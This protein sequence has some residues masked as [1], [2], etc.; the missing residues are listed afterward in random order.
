MKKIETL[1]IRET[2]FKQLRGMI[3]KNELRPGD[4]LSEAELAERL[5]VSRTPIREALHKLELEDLIEIQPRRYCQVKGI[6]KESIN[7]INL[8]RAQLEPLVA[9]DAVDHLTDDELNYIKEVLDRSVNYFEQ[10]DVYSLIEAHD[11]FHSTI[12]KASK[13]KRIVKLLENLHDY[14]ISFRYSFMSRPDL[15]KRSIYEHQDIFEALEKR[16]SDKVE[17]LFRIHLEGV[18]DYESVVLEDM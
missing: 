11:E 8:I 6:T 1:S 12:L 3:L 5:G 14:I 9:R 7:E 18:L 16:D 15:V 10:G 17:E 2:I 13:L 4:K